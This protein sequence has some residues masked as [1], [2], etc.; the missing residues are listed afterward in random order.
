MPTE[1]SRK[2]NSPLGAQKPLPK[3]NINHPQARKLPQGQKEG[4]QHRH[5]VTKVKKDDRQEASR[6]I[7]AANRNKQNALEQKDSLR[8]A[9]A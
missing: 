7:L 3:P 6:G 2:I 8:C 4:G 9:V 1:K 5:T